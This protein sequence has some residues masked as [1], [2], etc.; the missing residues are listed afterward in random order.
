MDLDGFH[1]SVDHFDDDGADIGWIGKRYPLRNHKLFSL[2]SESWKR[3]FVFV[4]AV[5][6]MLNSDKSVISAKIRSMRD[7]HWSIAQ[8]CQCH[9]SVF[10]WILLFLCLLFKLNQP[11]CLFPP[12]QLNSSTALQQ[13]IG[14]S[15]MSSSRTQIQ[16]FLHDRCINAV[17]EHNKKWANKKCAMRAIGFLPSSAIQCVAIFASQSVQICPLTTIILLQTC[18]FTNYMQSHEMACCGEFSQ[19]ILHILRTHIYVH[20]FFNSFTAMRVT[21]RT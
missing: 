9:K 1:L 21:L 8:S 6:L 5:D 14:C 15:F 10:F 11:H 17:N 12:I 7:S 16:Y 2:F 18:Q 13:H 19:H 3:I 20:I 4:F